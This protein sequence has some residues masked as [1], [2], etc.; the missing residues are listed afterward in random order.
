MAVNLAMIGGAGWQFFD[1]NGDVLSGGKVYTYAAGTTTPQTTYTDR[2]GNVA[3]TN[4]IILDSAGRTPFQIWSTEGLLYKYTI[5]TSTDVQIRVWD[6]IGGSV[7]ASNLAADL[8]APAGS[9]LVGYLPAGTGAVATT[10]QAKLRQSVN[11]KDFGAVGDGVTDNTTPFQLAFNYVNSIGGGVV[12]IPPGTYRK[13]DAAGSSWI[14]YPNTTLRGE[15]D[16]STIF[17]DD[18]DSVVRSGNDMLYV[19]NGSNVA[20]EDFRITGTAFTYTNETNHKQCLTGD[21]IDGLRLTNLTFEKLRYMATAFGYC[22]NVIMSGNRLDYIVRDGL[23]CVQSENVT[24]TG[25]ILKH[26]ADD[27][28][29]VH[30]LDAATVPSSATVITDNILEACQGIKVLGAKQLI[31]RNNIIRRSLRSPISIELP[32]TGIEGNTPQFSIDVSGNVIT[33][34]SALSLNT[35]I[36][37]AQGLARSNGGLATFP[38]INST[39]YAYNYLNNIDT[40]TPVII[41]QWGIRCCD[42]TISRTLPT[43]AVYS[44]WG[45][46]EMFDRITPNLFSDPLITSAYFQTHGILV[47]AP[48][49]AVQIN[50]NNISG[51]GTGFSGVILSVVGTTNVQDFAS[52]AVQNNM[53]FDC[54]GTGIQCGVVGSGAGAKQLVVQ[55]N[56]FDLDPYFRSTSHNADNTFTS[57]TG[58]PAILVTSTIGWLAGGNV[59]KNC[60]TTGIAEGVLTESAPN[61]VYADFVASGDNVGNKGVRNLPSAAY[62]IIVPINGDP[63]TSTFGQIANTVQMQSVA[64]PTTGRYVAGHRVS[65]NIGTVA[66]GAG[67]QYIINGWTRLTTGSTHVL[68]TDW[69]EMRTLTGT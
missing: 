38:G 34:T 28:I 47:V 13:G 48:S 36:Y 49:T 54:P 27:A 7:V 42:N 41:G 60:S 68:N 8:A 26:V 31:V 51:M 21:Y 29:A 39:P 12:N 44:A 19:T 55:N 20:F 9:S 6:N 62:N 3:N 18:K 5:K 2:N 52:V 22:K 64:I 35:C 43:G 45:Y 32:A 14:M 67:S 46:G 24:I 63:T 65:K 1:N 25:N 33:D 61:I 16:Q 53:I 50:G 30:S 40:G 66:G 17:F 56:T 37:I 23:R 4:P 57:A 15:G 10:V 69:A 11:V 59:F 58:L